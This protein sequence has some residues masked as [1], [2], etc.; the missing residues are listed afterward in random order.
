MNTESLEGCRV[1]VV[2][3]EM[4]VAMMLEDM[5]TDLG[6]TVVATAGRVPEALKAIEAE[7]PDVAILDMNLNGERTDGLADT[8]AARGIPFAFATGY[9]VQQIEQPHRARP[10]IAKPFQQSE[11]EAALRKALARTA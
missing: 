4:L 2:E 5:L 9:G 7:A 6:C 3:D 1:L 8:L 10:L 11:L